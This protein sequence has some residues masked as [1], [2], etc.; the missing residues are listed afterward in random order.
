MEWLFWNFFAQHSHLDLTVCQAFFGS[1]KLYEQH[2][3]YK[4]GWNFGCSSRHFL[5]PAPAWTR[6]IH[7]TL[8]CYSTP[9]TTITPPEGDTCFVVPS[10]SFHTWVR[11]LYALASIP[12]YTTALAIPSVRPW[13]QLQPCPS[14]PAIFLLLSEIH[15]TLWNPSP[16]SLPSGSVP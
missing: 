6:I 7:V 10:S 9:G 14:T 15:D 1:R 13:N 8:R 12:C 4:T 11:A 16:I 3:S 5:W 2:R